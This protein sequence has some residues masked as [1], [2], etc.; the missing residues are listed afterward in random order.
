MSNYYDNICVCEVC[1]DIGYIDEDIVQCENGH[2]FCCDH[3]L[4]PSQR[5]LILNAIDDGDITLNNEHEVKSEYCPICQMKVISDYLLLQ[6]CVSVLASDATT[7][8]LKKELIKKYNGSFKDFYHAI[9]KN[10]I[11]KTDIEES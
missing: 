9:N 8:T 1:N 10:R 6:Y 3:I 2:C 7:S 11:D 4:Q 5:E